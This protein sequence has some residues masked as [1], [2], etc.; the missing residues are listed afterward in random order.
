MNKHFEE[1]R[2]RPRE[3]KPAVKILIYQRAITQRK[4]P[5]E[6]LANQLINEIEESGE[7]PPSLETAKRYI[8]K[9]RNAD[10]P[11]DEPW[12]IGC[13][14]EYSSFFPPDSIPV[15]MNYKQWIHGLSK[16][17]KDAHD[18]Y[19]EY[20]NLFGLSMS[21]I[22]IRQAMWIVRLEPL[23]KNV[24]ADEMAKDEN[25]RFCYP[26]FVAMVYDIAQTACEIL[27][28]RFTSTVLDSALA[29]ADLDTLARIGGL[30]IIASS[31]PSNCDYNCEYCKYMR[32]PGSKIYCMPKSKKEGEK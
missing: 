24:F 4:I 25:L 13:C 19:E 5:R 27:N 30:G 20:K 22:S 32:V 18:K 1:K 7:I 21:D 2:T 15:L 3:L 11:L 28:E 26:F 10:N 16:L 31:K 29:S 14:S 17:S 6:F 12:S 23:T 8:S 9:A